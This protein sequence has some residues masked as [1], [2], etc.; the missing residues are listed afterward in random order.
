[1]SPVAEYYRKMKAAHSTLP[2]QKFPLTF[3]KNPPFLSF[4]EITPCFHH[5]QNVCG[6]AIKSSLIKENQLD[7]ML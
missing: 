6:G 5:R 1:M 3:S 4:P 2:K 7:F